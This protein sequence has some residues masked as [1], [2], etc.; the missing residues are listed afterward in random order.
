[1]PVT[2]MPVTRMPVT[3]SASLS[4]PPDYYAL[5]W[6]PFICEDAAIFF[7]K[8]LLSLPVALSQYLQ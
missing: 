3:S 2:R 4:V 7:A 1:M 8:S 5:P 6:L